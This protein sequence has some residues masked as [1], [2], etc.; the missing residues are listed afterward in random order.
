MKTQEAVARFLLSRQ[1]KHLSPLALKWYECILGIFKKN[2]KKLPRKPEQIEG[3]LASLK[4][5]D[6]R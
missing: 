3:F 1:A 6:E 5:G 4:V 2:Y